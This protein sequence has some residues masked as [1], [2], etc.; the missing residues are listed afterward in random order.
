[1]K[2]ALLPIVAAVIAMLSANEPVAAHD[3]GA[4]S[5][6]CVFHSDG[7]YGIDVLLDAEHLPLADQRRAHE[8]GFAAE[9]A[10]QAVVAFDDRI[11]AQC[12]NSIEVNDSSAERVV[13]HLV[14]EIPTGAQSFT[15]MHRA[16]WGQNYL[17]L[18]NENDAEPT[19]QWIEGGQ[20]SEPFAL[21]VKSL[22][23]SRW[24][25]IRTYIALG[26]EHILPKGLDHILFVLGLFLLSLEVKP[27]LMQVTAFTLA[28]SVTLALSMYGVVSLPSSI[29]EPLIALSIV[30]VAVENIFSRGYKPWRSAVVF[31][32]GLL[33]GMGFAGVLTELGLPRSQFVPALIS[34]NIGVELGQLSV[35]A[36]A[37]AAVG[38]WFGAKP[39]YRARV[40]IPS[41]V[42]IA[43]VGLY[44]TIERVSA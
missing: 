27:I 39:W 14:G 32:F 36:M 18:Q 30:F 42:A 33:H 22:A 41:S 4:L 9:I 3:L 1:V 11:V 24:D 2:H 35:I 38:I 31:G 19:G 7:T 26:F 23:L 21:H 5:V 25:V 16:S 8:P 28:H 15:W 44:W 37:F 20:P 29:V 6:S 43:L 34:F 17:K 12:V 13:I 10:Q 40:T